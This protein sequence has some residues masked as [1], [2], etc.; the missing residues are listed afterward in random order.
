[1]NEFTENGGSTA[2]AKDGIYS[3]DAPILILGAGSNTGLFLTRRFAANGR[4]LFISFRSD[5]EAAVKL[6]LD[7]PQNILGAWPI[8]AGVA[9][10]VKKFFD[11]VQEKTD[12]LYAVINCIGHFFQA[13][14]METAEDEFLDTLNVNLAQA[15]FV[16]R[17]AFPLLKKSGNGR[18]IHFTMAGIEK[19]SG[20]RSV[21]AHAAAKAGL[22]SLT[23]SLALEWQTNGITVNAVAPGRILHEN[24]KENPQATLDGG[25]YVL[26]VDIFNAVDF[27]LSEKARSISGTNLVVSKGWGW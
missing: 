17:Q 20:Y 26:D 7:Y 14:L 4:K 13:P 27:L 12:R 19:L 6:Q 10:G 24:A 25:P 9:S 16:A 3:S 15:F 23:R 22:L 11:R 21:A 2:E 18:L 5:P 8:E 1:M